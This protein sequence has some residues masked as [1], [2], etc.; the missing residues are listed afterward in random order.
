MALPGRGLTVL[1][2][3]TA[4]Q[5]DE[6]HVLQRF[7]AEVLP[8]AMHERRAQLF[9]ENDSKILRRLLYLY[10]CRRRTLESS[11]VTGMR[12]KRDC[13]MGARRLFRCRWWF[14]SWLVTPGERSGQ[15]VRVRGDL[16]DV[17]STGTL[18]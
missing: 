15:H 4:S 5:S 17:V 3:C 8:L 11:Y 7:V 13:P 10:V 18:M 16:Q 1:P 2:S 9:R 6:L 12:L 14:M